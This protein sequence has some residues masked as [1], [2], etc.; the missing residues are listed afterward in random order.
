MGANGATVQ[1]SAIIN[2]CQKR[3]T[4][5]RQSRGPVVGQ[6]FGTRIFHFVRNDRSMEDDLDMVV[7]EERRITSSSLVYEG[8]NC[9]QKHVS[10]SLEPIAQEE[11]SELST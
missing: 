4:T 5:I 9:E 10:F 11:E 3:W 6:W 8:E 1:R 2:L 7:I